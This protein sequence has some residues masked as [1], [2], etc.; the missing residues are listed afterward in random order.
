MV[1]RWGRFWIRADPGNNE[2]YPSLRPACWAPFLGVSTKGYRC[3]EA[4]LVQLVFPVANPWSRR[5]GCE[6]AV[7]FRDA[8][9]TP[10]L[11]DL[12]NVRVSHQQGSVASTPLKRPLLT[13]WTEW[14]LAYCVD[15]NGAINRQGGAGWP[16]QFEG[17]LEI[18]EGWICGAKRNPLVFKGNRRPLGQRK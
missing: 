15:R 8:Q 2:I 4:I 16:S 11:D 1:A 9:P 17:R 12:W 18:K 10:A 6:I 7:H 5:C 13:V 3:D 14:R